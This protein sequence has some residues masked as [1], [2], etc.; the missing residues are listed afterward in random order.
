MAEYD[1]VCV[2]LCVVQPLR[3]RIARAVLGVV[4]VAKQRDARL[5]FLAVGSNLLQNEMKKKNRK[6]ST[7]VS[8]GY[9]AGCGAH[10]MGKTKRGWG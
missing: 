4:V 7:L 6:T 3:T 10:K 5:F 2:C 1:Y 9:S 8:C